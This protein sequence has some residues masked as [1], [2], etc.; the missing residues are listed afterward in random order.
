M[1]CTWL[2]IAVAVA[3]GKVMS[4]CLRI[5]TIKKHSRN[6]IIFKEFINFPYGTSMLGEVGA[7]NPTH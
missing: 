5:K 1:Q 6:F 4:A 7:K 2:T 3:K